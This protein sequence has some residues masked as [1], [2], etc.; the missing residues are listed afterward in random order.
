M[1]LAIASGKG[2]TGK[3][4]VAA[5]LAVT[6]ARHGQSVAYVDCDVEAPNGHLF[7]NPTALLE[8]PVGR[9]VPR[10]DGKRCT[11]C[12]LCAQFCRFN[13]ILCLPDQV[14]VYDELCHSC[15]GCALVCPTQAIAE[16]PHAIGLL[17]TGASQ[18]VQFVSGTL[19]V[20]E[21]SSPPAIR[22]AKHAAPDAHWTILDAPPGTACPMVETVRDCDCVLLVTEP[23]PFG[24]HDL[25]LAVEVARALKLA[26]G[27]VINRADPVATETRTWC[28]QERLPILAEIPDSLAIAK[29][30]SRGQLIIDAVPEMEQT[31][32]QLRERLL[33][34]LHNSSAMQ[35][36]RKSCDSEFW[37][38]VLRAESD[39][40]LAHSMGCQDVLSVGCGP[41]IIEA[42]LNRHGFRVTGLDV[43]PE[44]FGGGVE[45]VR[46]VVARAQDMPFPP[47]SFDAV[48]FVASLQFIEDWRNTL[49]Q[50]ARVL[51]DAGRL[52][53]MLLNPASGF[54]QEKWRDPHSYVRKMRHSDLNEIEEAVR[55]RFVVQTEY[56]LGIE[57][58]TL[59][60]SREPAS[61]ALYVIRG[62]RK[63]PGSWKKS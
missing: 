49:A 13:A 33:A 6:L 18:A 2:G 23:T 35:R 34:E 8:S 57:G 56:C 17:R 1:R 12:G 47:A 19:N 32:N 39:Y 55:K 9:L 43:T 5:N 7:L 4:T 27:V 58:T 60:E 52:V 37:Q 63:Q 3:T 46:T 10:V 25:R 28:E 31:F 50:A 62:V 59:F 38:N 51:R 14:L 42:A 16:E 24:L 45:G 53:V 21:T 20:G 54:F 11:L 22:A 30:Y 26:C 15:G 36:I 29:A 48:I 40:L 44:A 41:A 61:A